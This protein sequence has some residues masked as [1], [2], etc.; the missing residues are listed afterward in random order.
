[1]IFTRNVQLDKNRII[2]ISFS[3]AKYGKCNLLGKEK[4]A[5]T[6]GCK[7]N[8]FGKRPFETQGKKNGFG[9]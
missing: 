4:M 8:K 2:H 6:R 5:K 1:M 7:L 9:Q 3:Y